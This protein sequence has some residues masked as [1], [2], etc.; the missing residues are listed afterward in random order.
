MTALMLAMRN[1]HVGVVE[2]L[3][4]AGADCDYFREVIISSRLP[5][6][7]TDTSRKTNAKKSRLQNVGHI[8]IAL[9]MNKT[10]SIPNSKSLSLNHHPRY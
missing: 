9:I 8:I 10:D 3:L 2:V 4:E 5:M 6:H 1:D 7:V